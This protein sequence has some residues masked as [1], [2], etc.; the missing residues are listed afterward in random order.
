MTLS[1]E[2]RISLENFIQ[3][4]GRKESSRP[5]HKEVVEPFTQTQRRPLRSRLGVLGVGIAL[6]AAV[7]VTFAPPVLEYFSRANAEESKPTTIEIKGIMQIDDKTWEPMADYPHWKKTLIP[8]LE[9]NKSKLPWELILLTSPADQVKIGG[10]KTDP[11]DTRP[12]D[13]ASLSHNDFINTEHG[14]AVFTA[15]TIAGDPNIPKHP[16]GYF[17]DGGI[18]LDNRSS[19]ES[20]QKTLV[21]SMD[22]DELTLVFLVG[23]DDISQ[24]RL[25]QTLSKISPT[26][27]PATGKNSHQV[28]LALKINE[29]GD[30]ITPIDSE[31]N[32]SEEIILPEPFYSDSDVVSRS[33]FVPKTGFTITAFSRKGFT[34][35]VNTAMAAR[36]LP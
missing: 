22:S 30:V 18:R 35:G 36:P 19:L 10:L 11:N 15:F 25:R 17:T 2:R 5:V 7:G 32:L 29:K 16:E 14:V 27:N 4:G 31:G 34:N 12:Q 20:D 21:L 26:H 8:S 24:A 3:K 28:T 1:R 23:T 9:P 6:L 13:F 33:K